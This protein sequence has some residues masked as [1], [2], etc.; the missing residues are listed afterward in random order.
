MLQSMRVVNWQIQ[1]TYPLTACSIKIACLDSRLNVLVGI[2]L[3]S[4]IFV[5]LVL[6]N[7][8]SSY[9]N[10]HGQIAVMSGLTPPGIDC[11]AVLEILQSADIEEIK[12]AYRRLSLVRH[13]NKN[14][15][16]P[17]AHDA[18]CT[19]K[20]LGH[21]SCSRQEELIILSVTIA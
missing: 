9:E 18:F 6:L 3:L 14:P 7:P 4:H 16:D 2:L 15:G 1:P 17:G 10:G 8:Y 13:P 11:Y 12:R 19:V 5:L 20:S 21:W